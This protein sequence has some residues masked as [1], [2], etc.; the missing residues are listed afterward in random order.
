[1][2]R[3][4]RDIQRRSLGRPIL[5]AMAPD[6]GRDRQ[7]VFIR[8]ALVLVVLLALVPACRAQ[9]NDGADAALDAARRSVQTIERDL[10]RDAIADKGL[11][12]AR[13]R[14]LGLQQQADA[15]IAQQTP[16]LQAA[17]ARLAELG[18]APAQGEEAPDVAARRRE[19]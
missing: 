7:S 13:H 14:L 3:L 1:M 6:D 18:A 12:D 11:G 5:V 16:A 15:V 19:L 8:A 17:Q 10:Q 2:P 9:I 4:P